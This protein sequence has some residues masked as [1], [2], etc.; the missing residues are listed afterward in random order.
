M[1]LR[2]AAIDVEFVPLRLQR[3]TDV[4]PIFYPIEATA[5][6]SRY[7]S[8]GEPPEFR[9]LPSEMDSAVFPFGGFT[10]SSNAAM[11]S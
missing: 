11:A 2:F 5:L 8:P 9:A 7:R 10:V 4:V 6:L 3:R 1:G